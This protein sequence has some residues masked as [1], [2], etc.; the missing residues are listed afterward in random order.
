MS[1]KPD[2][3]KGWTEPE[4][5]ANTAYPPDYPYN[6]VTASESGH[7]F[8]MDDSK[9]RERVRLAH[10]TG[11]FIEMHPNGDEVHKV[12][13]D[14][15]EI[16]IKDKNVLIE[17]S[18]SVT[19]NGDSLVN[20]KGNKVEYIEGNYELHVK[21]T[22]SQLVEKNASITAKND[23]D[24]SAGNFATGAISLNA[25]DTVYVNSD[26]NVNGEIVAQKILSKGR[27]DA[28]AGVSAGFPGF[29]TQ[30]GG[31]AIGFPS[32]GAAVPVPGQITCIG[33]IFTA[34]SVNA[35]VSVNAPT[36]NFGTMSA[37]MM[38]DLINTV[39]FDTH[40]HPSPKGPTGV[41]TTPMV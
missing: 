35:L 11:T 25:P 18:C 5:A 21:G 39:I 6:Q 33:N 15:Y 28:I 20:I 40:I 31:L 22:Y 9:G 13:G 34:A 2:F 8:E 16:T 1:A 12:Y 3:F 38:T 30:T 4:S 26:L 32:P 41:P 24:L 10:R 36:G 23:L 19:I 7:T 14:G 27:I 37:V 17:G 29:V